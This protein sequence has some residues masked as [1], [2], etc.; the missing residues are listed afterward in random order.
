MP[1]TQL[2]LGIDLG[3]TATKVG[4]VDEE[5]LFVNHV[6]FAT[7]PFSTEEECASFSQRL[8]KFVSETRYRDAEISSI[9]I[10]VPGIVNPLGV[11]LVP[12]MD[13]DMQKLLEALS[14]S[15]DNVD[16][17]YLNDANAAA[18][19][20][21]RHGEGK[22]A[23]SML[24]VTLGTGVGSGIVIDGKVMEGANGAAGEI[25]HLKVVKGGRRCNCGGRGC[26][27]QYASSRG[28]VRSFREAASNAPSVY[29]TLDETGPE[30]TKYTPANES[31]SYT[32]FQAYKAGDHR[33]VHAV[34][35]LTKSL[36]L[37]L[38]QVANVIDPEVI[39]IGGGVSKSAPLFFP[40]LIEEY[41]KNA[42]ESCAF[43]KIAPAKLGNDAG[44]LGAA[45]H[46]REL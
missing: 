20:E 29:A 16:F 27:E 45:I 14:D 32:V 2:S 46:A 11:D 30:F 5:G 25:G 8:R 38:A 7:P 26:L 34:K 1:A 23:S 12:N 17:S 37:A 9:G 28:I 4:L 41:R 19:A 44:C 39:V 33:A 35:L 43:T 6:E 21:S 22:D 3:G 13:L 18:L 36:G 10:A 42:L 24:F 40:D 31:D 15:F